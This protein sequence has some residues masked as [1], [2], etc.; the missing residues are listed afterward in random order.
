MLVSLAHLS[1]CLVATVQGTSASPVVS[2]G[3]F[4]YHSGGSF[5][6]STETIPRSNLSLFLPTETEYIRSLYGHVH[7]AQFCLFP[8]SYAAVN[9]TSSNVSNYFSWSG[10]VPFDDVYIFVI[11]NCVNI[12]TE[13]LVNFDLR[14]PKSFLDSRTDTYPFCFLVFTFVHAV[15]GMFWFVNL[16]WHSAFAIDLTFSVAAMPVVRSVG[17]GLSAVSW[18][19]RQCNITTSVVASGAQTVCTAVYMIGLMSVSALILGGWCLYRPRIG[20]PWF[21]EIVLSSQLTVLA[22]RFFQSLDDAESDDALVLMLLVMVGILWFGKSIL[23]SLFTFIKLSFE[24]DISES[25]ARRLIPVRRYLILVTGV[26]V[27]ALFGA[28]C[29]SVAR[30]WVVVSPWVMESAVAA[31]HVGQFV[32]FALAKAYEGDGEEDEMLPGTAMPRV[33]RAPGIEELVLI[34]RSVRTGTSLERQGAP[35]GMVHPT[36]VDA[37]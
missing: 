28:F 30:E 18:R 26:A 6:I 2:F 34:G 23:L 37:P 27:I 32:I 33:L 5:F 14:N 12:S 35:S 20:A 13:Y 19:N 7:P 29:A 8:I 24:T 16:C 4:G 15:V 21:L 11:I 22:G 36:V 10:T 1:A 25:F 17:A 31:L 9:R 3:S